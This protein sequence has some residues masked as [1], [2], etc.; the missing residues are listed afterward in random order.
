MISLDYISFFLLCGDERKQVA[1][2]KNKGREIYQGSPLHTSF[3]GISTQ[4]AATPFQQPQADNQDCF[5]LRTRFQEKREKTEKKSLTLVGKENE[6]DWEHT[7]PSQSSE[8]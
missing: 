1:E 2:E 3:N 8:G 7:W 4:T 6:A 5:H